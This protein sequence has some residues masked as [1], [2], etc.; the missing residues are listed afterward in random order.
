MVQYTCTYACVCI[1]WWML[2]LWCLL[3]CYHCVHL[4]QRSHCPSESSCL[5]WQYWASL[6]V[7]HSPFLF[8]ESHIY[9]IYRHTHLYSIGRHG[10]EYTEIVWFTPCLP[11]CQM[12]LCPMQTLEKERDKAED[13]LQVEQSNRDSL[14]KLRKR[15]EELESELKI[16]CDT[17]VSPVTT[18]K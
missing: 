10:V 8:N 9:S 4:S 7:H 3:V 14:A 16:I 17:Q 11:D 18:Q 1:G 15:N 6:H 2:G 12:H 5:L 13:R